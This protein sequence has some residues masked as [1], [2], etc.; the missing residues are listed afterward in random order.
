MAIQSVPDLVGALRAGSF[1]TNGQV[2]VLTRESLPHV[3]EPG[4]GP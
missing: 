2:D 1:L 4:A 3:T